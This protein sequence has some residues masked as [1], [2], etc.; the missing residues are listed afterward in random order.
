MTEKIAVDEQTGKAFKLF[1]E[2]QRDIIAAVISMLYLIGML[3]FLCW[4]LFDFC[5]G[6]IFLLRLIFPQNQGVIS[7]PF[8]K[9]V[10]YTVIGGGLGGIINGMRSIII[11]HSERQAFGWRFVWK[12]VSLPL[13]GIV[14]AAIV[15]AIIRGGIVAFAGDFGSNSS[16][17]TQ[18]LSAFAIGALAGYGSNKVFVWLDDQVNRLLKITETVKVQVPDLTG[19]TKE[20]AESI[21]K[22]IK[23][24]L[25]KIELILSDSPDVLGKV[26]EQNP[27]ADTAV[28]KDTNINI[29][30]AVKELGKSSSENADG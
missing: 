3:V 2:S 5:V 16:T 28:S 21:L 23:L 17:T 14:L 1:P 6:Q 9:L 12:Y 18:A 30:I 19:K 7:S 27:T 26:I 24:N 22:E 15:Y 13:V 25:G 20:E 10:M 4:L 11:W 8:F 29:K